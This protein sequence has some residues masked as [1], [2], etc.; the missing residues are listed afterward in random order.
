MNKLP[1]ILLST[2][3]VS[4]G[5]PTSNSEGI[6]DK[7]TV[8]NPNTQI[9][10]KSKD[11]I[12]GD[13][14]PYFDGEKMNYFYLLHENTQSAVG[15]HPW[16]LLQT[17]DLVSYDDVG[18]VIPYERDV[19]SQDL[20]LGTGSV[21]KDKNNLYHAFY[22]GYNGTGNTDFH[23]KIQHATSTNLVTWTKHPEDGFYGGQND[24]RDPYVLYMPSDNL[25]WMLITTRDNNSGVIKLYK[26]A[27]LYNWTYHSIFFRNDAGSYNMECPTLIRFGNYWYLSYSEQGAYRV[28]HYRYRSDLNSGQWIEPAVDYFDGVGFYAGRMEIGWNRLFIAGWQAVKMYDYDGGNFDWGGNLT[29]HELIA[30]SNG[31]LRAKPTEEIRQAI[32]T[33]VHYPQTNV[34]AGINVE[35]NEIHSQSLSF[36]QVVFAKLESKATRI[37]F[38]AQIYQNSGVFGLGF[39]HKNDAIYG[40]TNVVF[41]LESQKLEFYN[42]KVSQL[43]TSMPQAYVPLST[44]DNDV[45]SITILSENECLSVYVE[46]QQVLSTRIYEKSDKNFSLFFSN[47]DIAIRQMRFY[48]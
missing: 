22:T 10:P 17:E 13:P 36:Q 37:E 2:L 44:N 12:V 3:L 20:A 4:C 1:L 39:G 6:P 8:S 30:L 32:D 7:G 38:D 19:A 28:T 9:F 21:I 42:V 26:S 5:G 47:T 34:S 27:D 11:G 24:F 35:S 41:N 48:E 14:M 23:E 46:G 15:F 16:A 43:S 18:V 29:T 40:E 45:L 31:E 33:E 25:Y